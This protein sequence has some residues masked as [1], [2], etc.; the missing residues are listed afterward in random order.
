MA[1]D[2]HPPSWSGLAT[3]WA[4]FVG[5]V[6]TVAIAVRLTV[7]GWLDESG[8]RPL[9]DRPL[10]ILDIFVN[11][12]LLALI[13]LVGG[14]LAAGHLR[15]GRRA[16]AGV[17]L[18]LPS[19]V[20]VRSLVTIGAVGGADPNWLGDSVRW[21][22]LEVGALAV[23]SHTGV[24]LARHPGR[25]DQDGPAA[26]RRALLVVVGALALAAIVEVMTA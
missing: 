4:L 7:P 6:L 13:P 2:E 23:A 15:E 25:R 5:V 22:S 16:V 11:N 26:M 21:W 19:V 14:W 24:W 12:S 9:P 20:V 18:L 10:L 1:V 8:E 17:F 3:T